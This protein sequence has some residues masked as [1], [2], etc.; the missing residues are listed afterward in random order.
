MI[1]IEDD[2]MVAEAGGHVALR[3]DTG[4]WRVPWMPERNLTEYAARAAMAIAER[5]LA[6][7]GPLQAGDFLALERFQ[8]DRAQ[9][10]PWAAPVNYYPRQ[11]NRETLTA[12]ADRI[13]EVLA[14]VGTVPD[15][16]ACKAGEYLT[17]KLGCE[18]SPEAVTELARQGLIDTAGDYKDH[19]LYSGYS[20]ESF[21]D[22]AAAT[23]AGESGRELHGDEAAAV[24]GIRRADFDHL[25]RAERVV[26]VR[27]YQTRFGTAVALYRASDLT[28]L[29]TKHRDID[30]AAVRAT[31]KGRRSALAALTTYTEPTDTD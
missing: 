14:H 11:W 26:P 8:I 30:W 9:A 13:G 5:D 4:A 27:T 29:E 23:R 12:M 6:R 3:S 16:G 31:G 24:L 18:V 15:V 25:V 20:L 2:R 10:L 21:D 19:L 28:E 7:L 1:R 17:A 22:A